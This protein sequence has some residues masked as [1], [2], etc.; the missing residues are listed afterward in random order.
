MTS[1]ESD[2]HAVLFP[3]FAS[4]ELDEHVTRFLRSGGKSILLGEGREEYVSR[5]MSAERHAF[6]T[7]DMFRSV[8]ARAT[9]LAGPVLVAVDQELA[10]I[11]RLAVLGAELPS[12]EEARTMSEPALILR[13]ETA[14]RLARSVGVNLFLAP[15]LDV[16]TGENA[17]LRGRTLGSDAS[18]VSRLGAAFVRGV[19]SAGVAATAKHFPGYPALDADPAI[20]DTAYVGELSEASIAPFRSAIAAGVRAVMTG[21]APVAALGGETPASTSPAVMG[22]LRERLGFQGLIVTD[23]LDSKATL[24]GSAVD[25]VAI[26]ALDAGAELLLIAAGPHLEE[27]A[28]AIADAVRRGRLE[29]SKLT[30]A[31]G[32]VRALADELH[33]GA[34][35]I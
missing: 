22:F 34:R 12:L 21:P 26:E 32:K 35:Q 2:A 7:A 8:T 4:L 25:A 16:V 5:A 15:I 14:A 17:W 33:A 27:V 20:D 23:D 13:C 30:R 31:A 1:I 9:E 6:E 29:P 10:G 18:E 11:Q 24:R 19:Q 3:A 28:H